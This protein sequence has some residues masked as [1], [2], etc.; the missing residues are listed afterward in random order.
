VSAIGESN[1]SKAGWGCVTALD[2]EGRT[3]WT[4]DAHCDNG[5]RFVVRADEI[6]SAFLKPA[7][8]I[9]DFALVPRTYE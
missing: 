6:L 2:Y 4:V 9:Y 3:I 7:R 5:K 1:L 8:A